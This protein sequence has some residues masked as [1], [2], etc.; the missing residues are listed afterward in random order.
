MYH[1]YLFCLVMRIIMPHIKGRNLVLI[2]HNFNTYELHLGHINL[3]MI[4]RLVKSRI[5]PSLIPEDLPICKSCTKSKMTKRSFT[6]KGYKVKKCL[7]LVHTDI[8]RPL[9]SMNGESM[10][11]SLHLQIINPS[12]NMLI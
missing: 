12:S 1:H 11:D 8:Y 5:L 9:M 6:T 2:K 4:E 3:N 10:S 7:K